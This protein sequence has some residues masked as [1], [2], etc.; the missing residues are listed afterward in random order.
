M[1]SHVYK[2]KTLLYTNR[3]H[4]DQLN[5]TVSDFLQLPWVSEHPHEV[6]TTE[7]TLHV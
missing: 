2:L 1:K 4:I 5:T 7:S 6:V 3:V